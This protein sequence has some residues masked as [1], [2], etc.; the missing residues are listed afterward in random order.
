ML[1]TVHRQPR[2]VRHIVRYALRIGMYRLTGQGA[3]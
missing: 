3:R 1:L 2:A